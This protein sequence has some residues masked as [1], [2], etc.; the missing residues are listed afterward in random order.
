MKLKRKEEEEK[1]SLIRVVKLVFGLV[2][3]FEKPTEGFLNF[4]QL[5][6]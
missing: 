5:N 2:Y 1:K 4:E 3:N 6:L